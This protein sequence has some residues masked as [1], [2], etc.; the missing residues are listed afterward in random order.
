MPNTTM[1]MN[2][3]KLIFPTAKTQGTPGRFVDIMDDSTLIPGCASYPRAPADCDNMPDSGNYWDSYPMGCMDVY[4]GIFPFGN[5]Y[6]PTTGVN[7]LGFRVT[8]TQNNIFNTEVTI[9]KIEVVT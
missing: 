4:E 2:L 8:G 9:M 3:E 7:R 6:A 1:G 5:V